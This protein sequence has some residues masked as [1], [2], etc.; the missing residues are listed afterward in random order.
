MPFIEWST[1]LQT[2]T[3]NDMASSTD[4]AYICT[5][6]HFVYR[7]SE[8]FTDGGIAPG[9]A[10][11]DVPEDWHCPECDADKSDFVAHKR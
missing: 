4:Q 1:H 8:G 11:A 5:L 10:W 2:S 7:P 9:T 6:C 3:F